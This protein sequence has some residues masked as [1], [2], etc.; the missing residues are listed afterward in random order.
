MKLAVISS[1]RNAERFLPLYRRML[2][3]FTWQPSVIVLGENDSTDG[4]AA[5][6]RTWSTDWDQPQAPVVD[7]F[8]FCTGVA[9][10]DREATERRSVYM[11]CV[12]NR[13]LEQALTHEW[14]HALVVSTQKWIPP[15][16][17]AVMRDLGYDIAA[18]AVMRQGRFYDTW[19]FR[20][21]DQR[22]RLHE[23]TPYPDGHMA[24]WAVGGAYL[25]K[26]KVFEIGGVRYHD[27]NGEFCESA[28]MCEEARRKGFSVGMTWDPGVRAQVCHHPDEMHEH[29]YGSDPVETA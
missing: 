21:V 26:R 24:M 6:L 27:T 25:V 23:I 28:A 1:M 18:V 7:A 3:R 15:R 10:M 16:G 11:A 19:C 29:L 5:Y 9:T 22:G 14:T 20:Q 17:P 8:S 12:W 4:T 13:V 2:C